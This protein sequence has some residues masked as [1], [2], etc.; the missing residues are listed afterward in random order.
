MFSST[1]LSPAMS[2]GEQVVDA[3]YIGIGA[4]DVYRDGKAYPIVGGDYKDASND[5][6]N[7]R[8][9]EGEYRIIQSLSPEKREAFNKMP[10]PE[11]KRWLQI[12][13]QG[14]EKT[15][16]TIA[17]CPLNLF[18][19]D[20]NGKRSGFSGSEILT[21]LPDVQF[22]ILKLADGTNYT[23]I[24]YPEN[25]NY[26]LVLEGTDEGQAHVF[27]GHTLL[28]GEKTPPLQQYSFSVNKDETYQIT[29][30]RLGAPMQREG[31]SL[32][33]REVTEI[34]V[35]FLEN[36]PKL[37][38][39]GMQLPEDI[40]ADIDNTAEPGL[41]NWHPPLWQAILILLMGFFLLGIAMIL[42]IIN[43]RKG[44][45]Q[46]ALLSKTTD[47][48]GINPAFWVAII[49]LMVISCFV[50]G[51]GTVG[52]IS[53]VRNFSRTNPDNELEQTITAI[54]STEIALATQIPLNPINQDISVTEFEEPSPQPSITS[55]LQPSNTQFPS[56]THTMTI[57][58]TATETIQSGNQVLD[59][60]R[61]VDDFS[62]Q[63]LGWPEINDG[64]KILKYENG[65]YSFQLFEKDSF[66][67]VHLP[68]SFN[69][70]EISF[71]VRGFEGFDD[72]TF[73]IFCHFQDQ[74]NYY[75]V[76][77][78]MLTKTYVI[79][80]SLN[81]E[82]VPLTEMTD[83]GQYWHDAESFKES[84]ED[85]KISIGCYLGNIFVSVNDVLVDNV[86]IANPF[87][88][89]G[90]TA[91]F[92]YTYPFAGEEGYKVIFDNLEAFDPQQ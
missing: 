4:S 6:I 27:Q 37:F 71:S 70:S 24:T 17:H 10:K 33:P 89:K 1:G 35:E 19:E 53:N 49:A 81:G 18:I 65:G 87:S 51:F 76:E 63:L 29:T 86:S 60:S 7:I 46:D 79:A 21:E 72:G 22:M 34:S 38:S 92:V 16:K 5:D 85:N 44:K 82:Y 3:T 83:K 45:K 68:V 47:K 32:E 91:L 73:G 13:T 55:T 12:V 40:Q 78:D 58:P 30:D 39:P 69:P 77:F 36:L 20:A 43:I 67:V 64:E 8:F 11:Q 74:N 54:N 48:K 50:S 75:Y 62:S 15:Q 25:A 26:T 28:L 57:M 31:G 56:P 42:L 23:E 90:R 66:D 88:E 41:L 59:D 61:I 80:Q 84:T 2:L 52:V 9:S 14:G